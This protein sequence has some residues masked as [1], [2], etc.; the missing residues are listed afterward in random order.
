MLTGEAPDHHPGVAA[1]L[2]ELGHADF[3]AYVTWV[4][5]RALERGLLPH[6]NLG[7]LS[8]EDLA[9]PA[10]GDRLAGTDARI[11]QP[12]PRRPPGLADQAPRAPARVHP[13]RRRAEDPVHQRHPGRHRR[14][15]GRAGRRARGAR[16][17][18]RR[19]RPPAGGDPAELRPAPELLRRRSRPRSPRRLEGVLAHRPRRGPAARPPRMVH[20]G[21]P[22]GH[23]APDRRDAPADA[24]RRRPGAAE[25][26]RLVARARRRRR[27][28][29]RRPERQRRPHLARAPVPLA[30]QGP[31]APRRGRRRADRAAVRLRRVHRL[32]VGR[33]ARAGRDQDAVLELHPAPRL[34]PPLGAAARVAPGHDRARPRRRGAQRR[35][36]DGDVRRDAPGGDRGHARR[37]PTRCAPSWRATR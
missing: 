36:D 22:R 11:G 17:R 6:T 15:R 34:G 31:Q 26:R 29:P 25:P 2:A 1:K 7:V 14:V 32:R 30:A 3:T 19:A 23:E 12:G 27:D 20:A 16:R 8:R 18:T 4:C 9:P 5:E 21:R 35:G 33:P 24:R 13:H 28:R 37:P 10:R